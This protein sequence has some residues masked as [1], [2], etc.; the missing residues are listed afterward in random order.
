MDQMGG[1]D[2]AHGAVGDGSKA[3]ANMTVEFMDPKETKKLA[4]GYLDPKETQSP[5][6]RR[7]YKDRMFFIWIKAP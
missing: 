6:V 3:D 1:M 7:T 5:L 2:D 4:V